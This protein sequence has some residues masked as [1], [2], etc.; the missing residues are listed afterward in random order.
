MWK[1]IYL[2]PASIRGAREHPRVVKATAFAWA[3]AK[4]K[5]TGMS[6]GEPRAFVAGH[7][8]MCD[9][10]LLQTLS[11]GGSGRVEVTHSAR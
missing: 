9:G 4:E 11:M 3:A 2:P 7:R 10:P 6:S 8:N 5:G 1:E